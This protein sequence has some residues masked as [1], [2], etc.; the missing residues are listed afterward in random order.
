MKVRAGFVQAN[1]AA[2]EFSGQ[3]WQ[4]VA[5]NR[6]LHTAFRASLAVLE[7]FGA[8]NRF[9]LHSISLFSFI[10]IN[11]D[12]DRCFVVDRDYQKNESPPRQTGPGK[13][14]ACPA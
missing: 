3:E 4:T 6:G 13:S 12:T 7:I 9:R 2:P 14:I 10:F 1:R 5:V 11:L 8:P